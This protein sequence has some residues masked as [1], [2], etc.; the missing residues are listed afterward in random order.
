MS[1]TVAFFGATGGVT[2][3]CLVHTLNAGH[4]AIALVRTPWKLRNQL[5]E[6]GISESTLSS[7]LN[8]VQGNATD[9]SAVKSTLT[10]GGAG[11]LPAMII[12]GLGAA[13]K[14]GWELSHP[15]R[16]ITIDQP[17]L[18]GDAAH[19]LV[20]AISEL[21]TEQ[22]SLKTHKPSLVFVSTTGISRGP[23]DVPYGMRTF[24]HSIL[25]VPHKDKKIMEETYRGA[26][27]GENPLFSNV[28]GIRPTWLT[29]TMS[30]NDGKGLE[31]V[32]AGTEDKPEQG[33]SIARA[34]VGQWMFHNL[35]ADMS[36]KTR[37][38]GQM[39]S[40]TH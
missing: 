4:K 21:Y 19:V 11:T 38:E 39:C 40:L 14:M 6:Q 37:W 35:I 15:M 33:F 8:I 20:D 13:P 25:A 2:G 27:E 9:K 12:T 17:T 29:G 7:Q 34:D 24:Y 32:K 10:A 36:T 3:A 31:H 30:V 22:P 1:N 26:I 5:K 18:C 23:E 16:F 28:T